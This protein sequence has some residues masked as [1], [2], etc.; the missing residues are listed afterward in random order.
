VEV[1]V[2]AGEFFE[3]GSN[4]LLVLL[5]CGI[6]ASPPQFPNPTA[7]LGFANWSPVTAQIQRLAR[8]CET[9]ETGED[10]HL[11]PEEPCTGVERCCW[12]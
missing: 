5:A 10:L 6:C 11:E 4:S 7:Q 9:A 12:L 2:D 8:T 1:F 3:R